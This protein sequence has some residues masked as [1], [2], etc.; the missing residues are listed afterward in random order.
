MFHF[1]MWSVVCSHC[2]YLLHKFAINCFFVYSMCLNI[3]TEYSIRVCISGADAKNAM[4]MFITLVS[5]SLV[6]EI[7]EIVLMQ[8]IKILVHNQ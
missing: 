7:M 5:T 3:E 8:K 4:P 2:P 6:I 1:T